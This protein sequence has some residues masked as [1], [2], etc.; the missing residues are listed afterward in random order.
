MPIPFCLFSFRNLQIRKFL[1][2]FRY[3]KSADFL[4][5]FVRKLQIH[6]FFKSF[7]KKQIR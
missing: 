3:T 6:N 4:G 5:E 2:L 1:G 7:C